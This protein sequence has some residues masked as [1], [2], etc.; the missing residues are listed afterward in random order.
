[1]DYCG[2]FHNRPDP[3]PCPPRKGEGVDCIS[4]LREIVN[5]II[6][7]AHPYSEYYYSLPSLY[8]MG[9]GVGLLLIPYSL[10]RIHAC[11][12]SCREVS[13]ADTDE[14]TYDEADGDTP[15][16]TACREMEQA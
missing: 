12:L 1:M 14:S 6:I 10:D 2:Y 3:S 4:I 13:E 9:M 16:W 11:S 15:T 5:V 8:G 7:Q